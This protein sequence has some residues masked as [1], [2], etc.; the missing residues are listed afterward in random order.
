[1]TEPFG[2]HDIRVSDAVTL[3]AGGGKV[4]RRLSFYVG[5]HGPFM[6]DFAAGD[7]TAQAIQDYI[8]KQV[9]DLRMIAT[10]QY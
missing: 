4:V 9:A 8:A 6:K 3:T 7:D 1:M 5:A 2:V 10:R